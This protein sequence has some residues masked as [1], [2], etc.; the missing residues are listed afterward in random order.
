MIN[1][2]SV[3]SELDE[4]I[5]DMH[6]NDQ[7][8][9]IAVFGREGSGKSWFSLNLAVFL[10]RTINE[11]N[12]HNRLAQTVEDFCMKAPDVKSFE[13]IFWDEAHR[14]S[15]RG[16]YDTDVN[17]ILLE[18]FQDIR[19]RR[20]IYILCFPELR[21]VDRKVIQRSRLFFETVKNGKDFLVKAWTA[22]QI[23][24]TID[25]FR[26]PTKKSKTDRWAGLPFYPIKVFGHDT[27]DYPEASQCS[28]RL[29]PITSVLALNTAYKTFK[30]GSLRRSDEILRAYGCKDA[31]DVCNELMRRTNLAYEGAKDIAYATVKEAVKEGWCDAKEMEVTE[32][33]RYRIKNIDFFEKLVEACLNKTTGKGNVQIEHRVMSRAEAELKRKDKEVITINASST[34]NS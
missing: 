2:K 19:G 20:R 6:K 14:F 4:L 32:K 34:S 27:K 33:G 3:L 25:C 26:L 8:L 10:D 1:N 29:E 13:I 7:D 30:E 5:V 18:Y 28:T 16:S 24:A 11:K 31:M 15:K 12:L 21:E 22:K 9:V 23:E 17:R